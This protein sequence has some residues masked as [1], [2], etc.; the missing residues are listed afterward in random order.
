MVVGQGHFVELPPDRVGVWDLVGRFLSV[1]RDEPGPGWEVG[2]ERL[3]AAEAALGCSLPLGLREF[4]GRFG[5]LVGQ[6]WCNDRHTALL[7]P[8]R[9][10]VVRAFNG[11]LEAP[12][13]VFA[14]DEWGA[15]WGVRLDELDVPDPLVRCVDPGGAELDGLFPLTEFLVGLVFRAA[16]V[17]QP[18][19]CALDLHSAQGEL[20]Q[21]VHDELLVHYPSWD[22]GNAEVDCGFLS[23]VEGPELLA[24]LSE[25]VLTV[26]LRSSDAVDAL[27][28]RLRDLVADLTRRGG[29]ATAR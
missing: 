3:D 25:D 23:H 26:G 21:R 24:T 19:G 16:V 6:G 28:V 27:P 10:R 5:L 22:R 12:T 13:L 14:E 15:L 29:A 11:P 18:V 20:A 4:H 7:T 2:A 17:A 9:C 1:W 8:E